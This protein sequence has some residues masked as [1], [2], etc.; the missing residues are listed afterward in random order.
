MQSRIYLVVEPMSLIAEDLALSISEA[1]TDAQVITLARPEEA[2][3]AL[4][5]LA[6]VHLALVNTDPAG[7]HQSELGHAL[8]RRRARLLFLGND[9][10]EARGAV[11]VLMRPFSSDCVASMVAHYLGTA[12]G[13][14]PEANMHC[15]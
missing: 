7:F 6:S 5:R 4:D 14:E 12:P 11:P 1:D 9:A 13:E 15:A 10:E 2:L 3:S 8:M